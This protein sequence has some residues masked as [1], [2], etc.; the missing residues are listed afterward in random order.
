MRESGLHGDQMPGLENWPEPA[1]PLPLPRLVLTT[2]RYSLIFLGQLPAMLLFCCELEPMCLLRAGCTSVY[3]FP[4]W[5][6]ER[7]CHSP[8]AFKSQTATTSTTTRF[9]IPLMVC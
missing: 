6:C 3:G 9:R 5:Y 1:Q 4:T 7:D 8:K 2:M